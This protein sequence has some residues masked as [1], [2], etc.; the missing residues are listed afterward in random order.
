MNF[1]QKLYFE[2]LNKISLY[3]FDIKNKMLTY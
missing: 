1:P 3:V 2:T